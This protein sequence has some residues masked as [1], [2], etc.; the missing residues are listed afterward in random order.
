MGERGERVGTGRSG[1]GRAGDCGFI[2]GDKTIEITVLSPEIE[3]RE[4][5]FLFF[6][7]CLDFWGV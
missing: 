5:F 3:G 4:N 7:E 2:S 1:S 6:V